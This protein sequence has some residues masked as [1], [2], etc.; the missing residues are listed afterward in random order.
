MT[1]YDAIPVGAPCWIDLMSSDVEAS[2][3]FYAAVLGWTSE[4][5]N[6]DFG[7]YVNFN[8]DGERI[9]GLMGE[10]D[11]QPDAWSIYIAVEDAQATA[12]KVAEAGGTVVVPPMAVAELG[13]MAVFTDP[14]GAYFGIWQA[15]EHKGFKVT[16][17]PSSPSWFELHTRD[18]A[19][20]VAFY[21]KVFGW[22]TDLQGDTDDF[23]YTIATGEAQ[24]V[25]I[26]DATSFLPEGVP[27]HWS[28][29]F[30]V[31]DVAGTLAKAA[32]HGGSTLQGPDETPYG[33]LA[34]ATDSTGAVYKLRT[35]PAEG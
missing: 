31:E 9:A 22:D 28:V 10:Q 19:A 30:E 14:A 5:P 24:I 33:V 12:D 2:R 29:Y 35:A 8:R 4:E 25:G 13:S 15:N 32:E 23:R 11:G 34:V 18:F 21:E 3:A 20:S 6:P 17:E 1:H 27:N 16:G 26:M 7:G